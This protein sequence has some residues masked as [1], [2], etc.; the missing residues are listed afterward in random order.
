MSHGSHGIQTIFRASLTV[1]S[2][3]NIAILKGFYRMFIRLEAS[4]KPA[5]GEGT[6]IFLEKSPTYFRA[7][8]SVLE[9]VLGAGRRR[10]NIENNKRIQPISVSLDASWK[11]AKGARTLIFFTNQCSFVFRRLGSHL[12]AREH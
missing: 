1:L 2:Y 12:A 8:Y 7:S 9:A 11:L 3:G 6:L 10:G 4:R 5:G